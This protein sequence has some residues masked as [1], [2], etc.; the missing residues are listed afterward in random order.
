MELFGED[1][2]QLCKLYRGMFEEAWGDLGKIC[3]DKYIGSI[4][5]SSWVAEITGPDEKYGLFREF[6]RGKIDY[7]K[8]NSKGSRGIFAEYILSTGK[9]YEVKSQETWN[10]FRRYFCI[11]DND[12][13]IVE[14]DEETACHAVGAL[15]YEERRAK[16]IAEKASWNKRS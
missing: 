4:P 2:R 12:G 1:T 5:R 7:S 9:I 16:R 14:I 13:E 15:T 11:V 6:L 10:R 3:F 8:S